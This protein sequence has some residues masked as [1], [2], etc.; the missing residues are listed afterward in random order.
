MMAEAVE[1]ILRP[2]VGFDGKGRGGT[3]FR[4]SGMS[5]LKRFSRIF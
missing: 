1:A 2:Q 5:I 3:H 4:C